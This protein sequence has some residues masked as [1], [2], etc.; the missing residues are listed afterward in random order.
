[1]KDVLE[2][3]VEEHLVSY[4]K[5]KG[6]LAYKLQLSGRRGWPDQLIVTPAGVHGYAET[7]R[8]K[9]GKISPHQKK[10][11]KELIGNRCNHRYV[12]TIPEAEAFIDYLLT[13]GT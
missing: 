10:I 2:I 3:E 13:L 11:A 6:C 7:K 9:G 8:P 5:G 1:M 4:A 12:K